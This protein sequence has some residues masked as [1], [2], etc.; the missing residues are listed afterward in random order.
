MRL[1]LIVIFILNSFCIS[2]QRVC[3]TD[4]YI[5]SDF[6]EAFYLND[7]QSS[8]LPARDT[9]PNEIIT[10]PVVIHVLF[11]NA[12]QNISDEQILSQLEVLNKDFRLL[13]QDRINVPAAFKGRSADAK[14]MFC[15]AQVD[16]QGRPTTGILRRYTTVGTFMK[17]DNMKFKATGGSDAW[18][19]KNYLNIWVC[20]M[21]GRTLGYA[22]PPGGDPA[23][24]GVVMNYDVFGGDKGR[25]RKDFDK[26]RTGT[27]EVAH[28]M[29]L[30]HIWGDD[31]C[32]DD[33]VDDTPKQ[34]SYNFGCPTFP[35]KTY[36]SPDDNGD[37]YM[38]FMDLT[39][40]ACMYMFTNGQKNRM[41]A[42]FALGG[43]RNS[44]LRS[45]RC[46]ASLATGAPLPQDT[47]PVK[48][49]VVEKKIDPISFYPNPVQN[50]LNLQAKEAATLT[51][52]TAVIY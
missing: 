27:H 31:D 4:E 47:L 42:Q 8:R 38:N 45:Y 37:M 46:D 41:R 44:F 11:N 3:N 13:N 36:C 26:G 49:P 16:P 32:G 5:K 19:A 23:K 40:D 50:E 15:L 20:S 24:D 9:S 2:A 28:W 52:K 22:T 39:N 1:Y 12:G 35:R 10:I 51:G 7:S 21:F 33:E 17:A 25:L 6:K 34:T 30:K 43:K 48:P 14:I 29:G 18:D